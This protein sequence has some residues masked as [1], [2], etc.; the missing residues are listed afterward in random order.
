MDLPIAA[1]RAGFIAQPANDDAPQLATYKS[2]SRVKAGKIVRITGHEELEAEAA[3]SQAIVLELAN[4]YR[5]PVNH[6]WMA[7]HRAELGGYYIESMDGLRLY[8]PARDF[9]AG[10]SLIDAEGK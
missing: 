5:V 4:G 3:F 9:E 10:Y 6:G 8:M 2:L 1:I 7:V